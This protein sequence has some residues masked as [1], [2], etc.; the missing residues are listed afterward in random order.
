MSG[1]PHVERALRVQGNTLEWLVIFLP[2]LWMFGMFF[3]PR[4]GA[5]L[6]A[7]WVGGRIVY[8]T[9]YMKD[10]SKRAAGFAIQAV[11]TVI[12]LI[13]AAVGPSSIW[14]PFER[15]NVS[16]AGCSEN[17]TRIRT[18][19]QQWRSP[20]IRLAR[21]SLALASV[22]GFVWMMCSVAMLVA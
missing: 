18:K 14:A 17:K 7:V 22:A 19:P 11:A 8:M 10:P 12:L 6:G 15:P 16:K 13:G 4:I 5:A 2:A 9:G 1:H 20:M 3:D 21:E